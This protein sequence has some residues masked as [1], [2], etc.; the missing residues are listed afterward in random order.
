MNYIFFIGFIVLTIVFMLYT[1]YIIKLIMIPK[2]LTKAKKIINTNEEKSL[3]LLSSIL[4]TDRGNAEANWLMANI[5]IKKH[6][7]VLAQMYL[8]EIINSNSYTAKIS[9][10]LVRET[11][12]YTYK[13]VGE[14]NKALSQYYILK[15]H[16][17]L[18]LDTFI[19][20]IKLN[21]DYNNF[22]EAVGLLNTAIKL[23]GQRGEFFYFAG[24]IDF[25]KGNMK[26]AELKFKKAISENYDIPEVNLLLGKIYFIMKKFKLSIEHLN[27]LPE[28][29][30]N[31]TD[32]EKILGE[33]FYHLKNYDN[34]IKILNNFISKSPDNKFSPD[35]LFIL[36]CAY[37]SSGNIDKAIKIWESI[38]KKFQQYKPAKDKLF[39]YKYIAIDKQIRNFVISPINLFVKATTTLLDKLHYIIKE[40]LYEDEKN[41]A[42]LCSSD[43]DFHPFFS[44][45][46]IVTRQTTPIDKAYIN[47]KLILLNKNRAKFL[48]I[49]GPYFSEVSYKFAKS[50]SVTLYDF[51]VYRDNKIIAE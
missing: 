13:A 3:K 16:N 43:K 5:Y 21:I 22:K 9:E 33:C 49:I 42:Y 35:S 24:L 37:E 2:K 23:Y 18:T 40:K 11:L 47:E 31:S 6:Q 25:N 1:R 20:A 14:I 28:E 48:V 4:T 34:A 17:K 50:N 44:Y 46:I 36:G 39:F 45:L 26:A 32:I 41:L 8:I 27:N 38:T 15:K 51:S 12:S 10:R 29:Y 30:L 19:H 7:Y